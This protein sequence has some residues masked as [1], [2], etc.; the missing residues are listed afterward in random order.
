M[1]KT[2]ID[3]IKNSQTM[4]NPKHDKMI[5]SIDKFVIRYLKEMSKW[6]L[7]D[8]AWYQLMA[9]ICKMKCESRWEISWLNNDYLTLMHTTNNA[10]IILKFG[11]NQIVANVIFEHVEN[12]KEDAILFKCDEFETI[13][14]FANPNDFFQFIE[15]LR[16][17]IEKMLHRISNSNPRF[18]N[19]HFHFQESKL[20]IAY[21]LSQKINCDINEL[22][23]PR[24]LII[25]KSETEMLLQK[26]ILE[27][28]VKL[29]ELHKDEFWK[30]VKATQSTAFH[31][32]VCLHG[33]ES[34]YYN[35]IEYDKIYNFDARLTS[36]LQSEKNFVQS[37]SPDWETMLSF[38]GSLDKIEQTVTKLLKILPMPYTIS[39]NEHHKLFI[40]CENGPLIGCEILFTE[41]LKE[42][43]CNVRHLI[44]YYDGYS[45]HHIPEISSK[46]GTLSFNNYNAKIVENDKD[47]FY[48][49]F[50]D[51]CL[52]AGFELQ[53]NQL[54][55]KESFLHRCGMFEHGENIEIKLEENEFILSDSKM[56]C[57]LSSCIDGMIAKICYVFQQMHN[58]KI[59]N[60]DLLYKATKFLNCDV[61]KYYL[62]LEITANFQVFEQIVTFEKVY[63]ELR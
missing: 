15:S 40:K 31:H 38:F 41:T 57:Y 33:L 5:K 8:T 11:K 46:S 29:F 43:L 54:I 7:G 19:L 48:N 28:D 61:K 27:Q 2:V 52:P 24:D 12:E 63:L 22:K 47:L 20:N 10:R 21:I 23:Q 16:N 45:A 26:I 34:N 13:P 4:R 14:N 58:F 39:I 59:Q 9:Q 25:L 60:K 56:A 17:P 6:N 55:F 35:Y 36:L 49:W 53:G 62:N 1:L 42:A 3:T 32:F 37:N 44:I 30:D 18:S 50:D 51:K